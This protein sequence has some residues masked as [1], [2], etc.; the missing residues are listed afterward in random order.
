[1]EWIA[2]IVVVFAAVMAVF[3]QHEMAALQY[4]QAGAGG[5]APRLVIYSR[6]VVTPQG[7]FPAAVHVFHGRVQAVVPSDEAPRHSKVG[8]TMTRPTRDHDRRGSSLRR[9]PLIP[10]RWPSRER[11]ANM[12]NSVASS[13]S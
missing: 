9:E 2:A 4:T 13:V 7:T 6:R 10:R 3:I 12:M 8:D 11:H 5:G 1:M